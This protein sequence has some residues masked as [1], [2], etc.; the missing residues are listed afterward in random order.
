MCVKQEHF[1]LSLH[2]TLLTSPIFFLY[3]SKPRNLLPHLLTTP[4]TI[5]TIT[6]A[7]RAT[8]STAPPPLPPCTSL[9]RQSSTRRVPLPSNS[10][11][12]VLMYVFLALF[13]PTFQNAHFY[14]FLMP[15]FYSI[16]SKSP[17]LFLSHILFAT[18]FLRFLSYS[19]VSLACLL[20]SVLQY[21]SIVFTY[22]KSIKQHAL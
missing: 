9:Q 2:S 3:T 22:F 18:I 4:S 16:I 13:S 14:S 5:P 7:T 21:F 15:F 8:T 12:H 1:R 6:Q 19:T 20:H 17:P 11:F 10:F